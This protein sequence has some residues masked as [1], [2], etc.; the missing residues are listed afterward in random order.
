MSLLVHQV[1]KLSGVSVDTVRRWERK[2]LLTSER[3]VNGWRV[4]GPEAVDEL[5]RLYRREGPRRTVEVS[6]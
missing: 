4:Y 6:T 5:R 2:G 1:A 3:D